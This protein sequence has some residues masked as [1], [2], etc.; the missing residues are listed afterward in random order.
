MLSTLCSRK[1]RE[2][3]SGR[4]CGADDTRDVRAHGVHE[5]EVAGVLLLRDPLHYPCSHGNGRDSSRTDHGVDLSSAPLLHELPEED[6]STRAE[7]EGHKAQQDDLQ[8]GYCEEFVRVHGRAHGEAEE[9]GRGVQ[10]FVLR[11]KA[12]PVRDAALPQEVAEH[13]DSHKGDRCGEDESRRHGGDDGKEDLLKLRDWPKGVHADG[14]VRLRGEQLDHRRLDEGDEGHVAVGRHSYCPQDLGREFHGEVDARGA[15]RSSDDGDGG[16]FLDGEA[17]EH[18]AEEGDE[19]AE[20]RCRAEEKGDGV[21]KQGREVR[22]GSYAH[23]DDDGVDFVFRAEEDVP[24][25]AA[26]VHDPREGK[27]DEQAAESYGNEEQGFES[28]ADGEVEH[29]ERHEE[30]DEM[31]PREASE[32]R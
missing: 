13:E 24:E 7:D 1:E 10:Y 5:Q 11:R 30:H 21:G 22:Q 17:H 3:D 28:L 31:S 16:R 19:D 15:V 29:D 6:S 23:E 18:G 20:L 26:V 14:T 2:H 8:G 9:D 27:V 32:P 12:E 25:K 4:H